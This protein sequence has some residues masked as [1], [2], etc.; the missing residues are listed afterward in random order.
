MKL[1]VVQSGTYNKNHWTCIENRFVCGI[2]MDIVSAHQ[3]ALTVSTGDPRDIIVSVYEVG[4]VDGSSDFPDGCLENLTPIKQ[5][6]KGREVC[7]EYNSERLRYELKETKITMQRLI[8]EIF[9][10]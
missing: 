2:Y 3:M 10:L 1:Y 6:Y 9:K 8:D 4:M 7:V 5:L